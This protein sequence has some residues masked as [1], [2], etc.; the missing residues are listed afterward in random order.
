MSYTHR[1]Y[2]FFQRSSATSKETITMNIICGC[3]HFL[4]TTVCYTKELT[5]MSAAHHHHF[6]FMA[7]VASTKETTM[8][9]VHSSSL[10]FFNS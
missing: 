7:I 5:T 9:S 4:K 1:C 3:R 2:L 6:F 8:M 10:S